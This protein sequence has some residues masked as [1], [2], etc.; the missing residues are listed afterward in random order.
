MIN[1]QIFFKKCEREGERDEGR[2][3]GGRAIQNYQC[4]ESSFLFLSFP[5]T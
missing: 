4:E 1:E 5:F 2:R 3:D